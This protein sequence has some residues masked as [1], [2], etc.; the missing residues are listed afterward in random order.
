[1]KRTASKHIIFKLKKTKEEKTPYK[2]QW[3]LGN[4]SPSEKQG[5]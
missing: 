2:K 1:M 3:W 4:T 5:K